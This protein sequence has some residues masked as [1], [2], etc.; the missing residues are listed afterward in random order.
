MIVLKMKH[1]NMWNKTLEC[2]IRV[3]LEFYDTAERLCVVYRN[4]NIQ[5]MYLNIFSAQIVT[6]IHKSTV[7][8]V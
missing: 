2:N 6:F 4:K 1:E 3:L 5:I 8:I 7:Q